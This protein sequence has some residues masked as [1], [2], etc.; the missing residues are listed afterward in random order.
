MQFHA[1]GFNVAHQ[2]QREKDTGHFRLTVVP[3]G[4]AS[5]AA[6]PVE[7]NFVNGQTEVW[8]EPPAGDYELR[9]DLMDNAG[10]AKVLASSETKTVKLR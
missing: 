6:K 5:A 10:T 2:A 1:S 7:M 3:V 8:I 4:S 9:L